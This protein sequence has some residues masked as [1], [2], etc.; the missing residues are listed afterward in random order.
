MENMPATHLPGVALPRCRAQCPARISHLIVSIRE[1]MV[2][3]CWTA[4]E[5]DVVLWDK[6]KDELAGLV[7]KLSGISIPHRVTVD[8]TTQK[9]EVD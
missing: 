6:T 1:S 5:M 3:R 2:D 9:K 8:N 7:N 4:G